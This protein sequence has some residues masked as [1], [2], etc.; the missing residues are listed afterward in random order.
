MRSITELPDLESLFPDSGAEAFSEDYAELFA[1]DAPI[2]RAGPRRVLVFRNAD[3]RALAANPVV[4]NMSAGTRA[5]RSY[6]DRPTASAP[7]ENATTDEDRAHLS[8]LYDNWIFTANPPIHGPTR[9]LFARP[10]MPIFMPQ[11]IAVAD[12]IVPALINDVAGQGEIDFSFQFT[13]RLAAR[14]WGDFIGMTAEESERIV[15]AVRGM[16]PLFLQRRAPEQIRAMNAATGDYQH[17]IASAVERALRAGTNAVLN[18]MAA[19]FDRIDVEGKPESLGMA[20][21]SNLL[22]GFHTAALAA[23]NAVPPAAGSGSLGGGAGEPRSGPERAGR[24]PADDSA[25]HH[26]LPIGAGGLRVP[27]LQHPPG[28]AHRHVVGGRQPRPG[29]VRGPE[30]LPVDAPAASERD[31][32]RRHPHLPG[33]QCGARDHRFGVARPDGAGRRGR[34]D[35]PRRMD[36]PLHHAPAHPDARRHQPELMRHQS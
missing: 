3:L 22:D 35:R 28:H 9:N 7:L 21:A 11:F 29:G 32:W 23:T 12:R 6:L 20:L 36:P 27:G 16:G 18:D 8:R 24:G 30:Q 4:G 34:T 5:N 25:A 10:L 33:P 14:L 17:I 2:V 15:A 1:L 13:E 19:E 26:H 31:L